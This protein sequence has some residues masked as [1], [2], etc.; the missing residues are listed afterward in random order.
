MCLLLRISGIRN[1]NGD[2]SSQM[3][4][5]CHVQFQDSMGV[6]YFEV[7]IEEAV[8]GAVPLAGWKTSLKMGGFAGKCLSKY[9]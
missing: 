2:F 5:T 3:F 1:A 7:K 4:I 6:S 9:L 8:T